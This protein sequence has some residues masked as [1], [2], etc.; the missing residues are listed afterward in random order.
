VSPKS[1]WSVSGILLAL[2]AVLLLAPW[3]ESGGSASSLDSSQ[4]APGAYPP[5]P[6]TAKGMTPEWRRFADTVDR[7]C[8]ESWN[9][10]LGVQSQIRRV[11]ELRGWTHTRRSAAIWGATADE[12][13][14][15]LLTTAKMGA[16]PRR[17]NLFA[18]WRSNVAQR[19]SLFRQA[20]RAA[21]VGDFDR[22][23]QICSEI[24][25]LKSRS[26]VLGQ[27]FGLRICTSN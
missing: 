3:D 15:I 14:R 16:P 22:V 6:S 25:R 9:Y 5:A 20:S 23:A 8:A 12:D 21:S 17:E 11:A 7:T 13:D 4:V 26:D 10:L 24:N 27:R 2:I 18:R 19:T 1:F